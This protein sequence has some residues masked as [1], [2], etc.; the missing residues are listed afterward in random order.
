MS[1]ADCNG[2]Q[3]EPPPAPDIGRRVAF[4]R[5]QPAGILLLL[6]LPLLALSGS[7]D[8]AEGSAATTAG[9]FEVG[10]IYPQ[11]SRYK[12]T[13]SL[14]VR[15]RNTGNQ[16]ASQVSVAFEHAYIGAFSEVRFSPMAHRA[17][18][19]A[20]VVAL[21][22]IAPGETRRIDT[23]LKAEEYGRHRGDIVVR[24]AGE[25]RGRLTVETLTLP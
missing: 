16:P 19:D 7:L 12:T 21:D 3:A 1:N 17:T 6:A 14:E 9:E 11:R 8:V 20:Y 22:D 25:S 24:I 18:D 10:V 23:S 4:E 2:R 5:G 15:L 13:H